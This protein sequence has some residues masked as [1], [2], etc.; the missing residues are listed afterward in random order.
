M[1]FKDTIYKKQRLSADLRH[2]ETGEL[3]IPAN[4][5]LTQALIDRAESA[6]LKVTAEMF[7]LPRPKISPL[8]RS[9]GW[10]AD[11]LPPMNELSPDEDPFLC[12]HDVLVTV[13]E[14]DHLAVMMGR[15]CE[16]DGGWT[17]LTEH[18]ARNL[19]R[20]QTVAAWMPMPMPFEQ[21]IEP[22]HP[23]GNA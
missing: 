19:D 10:I 13:V 8:R 16:V 3:L 11:D 22:S 9:A 20:R 23:A 14:G 5:E 2:P 4:R 15:F 7:K 12:S 21:N 1:K 18:G 6:G 17:V